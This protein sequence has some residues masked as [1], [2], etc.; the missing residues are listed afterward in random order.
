MTPKNQFLR[1]EVKKIES[2]A[3]NAL[4]QQPEKDEA[5]CR[6]LYS[7]LVRIFS[8]ADLACRKFNIKWKGTNT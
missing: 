6:H 5:C 4:S 3:V 7:T 8:A 1:D 2:L